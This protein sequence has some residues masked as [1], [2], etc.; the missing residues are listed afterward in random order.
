MSNPSGGRR[1][2]ASG[3]FAGLRALDEED[4]QEGE[5]RA[6][7][8]DGG[9]AGGRA[10]VARGASS[11]ARVPDRKA[12][13]TD[14]RA[15]ILVPAVYCVVLVFLDRVGPR[16]WE[17]HGSDPQARP[18]KAKRP[19]RTLPKLRRAGRGWTL[20]RD[21]WRDPSRVNG[22]L[23]SSGGSRPSLEPLAQL[24]VTHPAL[25]DR[26]LTIDKRTHAPGPHRDQWKRQGRRLVFP[27]L[28]SPTR[29]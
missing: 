13:G 29:R 25:V 15:R 16:W 8:R 4:H 12:R 6:A 10:V 2:E 3:I 11:T 27:F 24:H 26:H 7:S 17:R 18:K 20:P 19:T 9:R 22:P 5:N 21:R 14:P 23:C 1:Q 28:H